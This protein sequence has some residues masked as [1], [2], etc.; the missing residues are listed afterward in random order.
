[1]GI[2]GTAMGSLA[3]ILQSMGYKV[4]GSD[5]N[6]YP[7]MST[8]LESLGI[9]IMQ[10]YRKENLNPRPDLVV[11][12]NVISSHFEEAQEMV[13]LEIPYTSLPKAMGEWVI[14]DRNSVVI[15]GTHGKTTTTSYMSWIAEVCG[16]KPGFLIGGIPL[17]FDHSFRSPTGDWFCIEGDEYDTAYF[18]KV[19]KFIHYKPKYVILT[20]VEFDHADIYSDMNEIRKAFEALVERIPEDGLLV[21]NGE[22]KEVMKLVA[23]AKCKVITYGLEHGDYSVRGRESVVGRN[24]FSV[25]REGKNIADI[26]IKQ[27]GPHNTMNA[28]ASYA[29]ARELEWPHHLILQG[30]AQF[31]GV[32]RRQEVILDNPDITVIDD[33]AHHPTAVRL[34]LDCMREAYGDRR[35]ICI[36]EPRSA[37][38]RRNV[39]YNEYLESYSRAD[40]V[41]YPKAFNQSKIPEADRFNSEQF[42]EDLSHKGVRASFIENTDEIVKALVDEHQAGDVVLIM[43]N[44]GFDGIYHKIMSRFGG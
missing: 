21:A 30:L 14:G 23:S 41:I 25:I 31:K 44:G 5:E 43:S 37:T 9:S 38:A 32:K 27:F 4:T 42:I 13:R 33:F 26:A 6:V 15:A 29:L 28:L 1:M 10:G 36:F 19:P 39:F 8:Q 12:G 7:P 34:T 3:G 24:Q 18:D 16:N 40:W 20:S 22:D 11:V 17:N 2:C 35:L